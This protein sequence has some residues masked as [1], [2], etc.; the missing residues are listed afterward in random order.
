MFKKMIKIC[1]V[2]LILSGLA[3]AIHEFQKLLDQ[4]QRI[5]FLN[6][7]PEFLP[8]GNMLEAMSMG[9]RSLVGDWLW[10]R[11]VLYYGRRSI[12]HDNPYFVYAEKN[13]P[14]EIA[15]LQHS[16]NISGV[17]SEF[18]TGKAELKT[19]SELQQELSHLLFNF[20][21]KGIV[22]YIYPLLERSTQVDPHF[23]FPYIF[24]GVYVLMETG[25]IKQ[26]MQLLIRGKQANPHHWEFP[27]YLGW[28]YWIYLDQPEMTH[29][30]LLQAIEKK[31]CP[32]FVFDLVKG[33]SQKLDKR[34]FTK[35][36]LQSLM[37]S[38]EN[39]E[40]KEQIVNILKS[41]QEN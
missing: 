4:D 37:E 30:L 1:A 24:G 31:D 29:Q 2:L 41:M 21:N 27:F 19:E 15:H 35:I 38:T 20:K 14:Q 40:I 26:S 32:A 22:D 39:P 33:M 3:F 34:N 28:I 10:I 9:Y 12:D 36:Y 13:N 17:L 6:E 5:L 7:N 8:R 16:N 23:V 11:S 18:D 25:E